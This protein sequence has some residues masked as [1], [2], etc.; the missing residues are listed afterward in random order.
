MAASSTSLLRAGGQRILL[1]E[2]ARS[3]QYHTVYPPLGLLKLARYHRSRGD[4][5]KLVSGLDGDGY[6]PDQIHVTSL[7]TYAWQPV[8]EAIRY[9]RRK[10]PKT[11]LTVGGIYAT[12]CPA[13]LREEFGYRIR[14]QDGVLPGLD[15]LRPDYSLVPDWGA[16]ILFSTR[17]CVRKCRFC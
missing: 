15:N 3:K 8:H 4:R 17:G 2:P 11:K 6:D 14:I 10:Y 1:V 12:L 9:Y 13:K 16:S 5:V 7:F